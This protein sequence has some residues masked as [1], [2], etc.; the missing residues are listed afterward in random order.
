M[1]RSRWF[2]VVMV[3]GLVIP[4]SVLSACETGAN[5]SAGS[6]KV[7]ALYPT[8]GPQGA[9]GSEEQ[10]GVA[11]AA[12]WA[13]AHHVLGAEKLQ[14]VTA[15]ADRAE[16]V[17]G[18]IASLVRRGVQVIV[19]SHGSTISAVAAQ[20]ASEQHLLLWETGAVGETLPGTNGGRSFFRMAPM[21]ANLGAA[22]ISFIA[23]QFTPRLGLSRPLRYAVTYVDDPYGRAVT[24][25]ALDGIQQLG[26]QLVGTFPYTVGRT[27][28]DALATRIAA[29]HPDVVYASAYLDDGVAVRRAMVAHHVRLLAGIGTS[30]SY[31]HLQF[32]QELGP[33]AVGL[34]ASD[35]PDAGHVRADALS[36]EGRTALAWV[37]AT[38]QSRFHLSMSAPALSGFSAAYALFVHVL[39][40]AK[41]SRPARV[42]QV[43]LATKLPEG[44]LANG[45]GMDFAGPGAA[46]AG[47][48]RAAAGVIWEW[49]G[50][51]QRAVVWP[52]AYAEHPITVLPLAA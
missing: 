16:E 31:C 7:G 8:A 3:A 46:D 28:Y 49:V 6:V 44:T 39:P 27:D 36:P 34:F 42:A 52:P 25:G 45:A 29:A 19:G 4:S 1:V 22:G 47:D 17:P 40:Q 18:A 14:L 10:Q 2:V 33:D 24:A 15:A 23:Q 50:P 35:K 13:N 26:L 30:S 21:G 9:Q 43:A 38:Y 32:G 5:A 48:N 51:G 41:D 37:S 12:E 11:L 20:M